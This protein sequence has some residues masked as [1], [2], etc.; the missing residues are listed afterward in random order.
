[1]ETWVEVISEGLQSKTRSISPALAWLRLA[2]AVGEDSPTSACPAQGC[3]TFLEKKYF[4]TQP[5]PPRP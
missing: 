2:M 3:T 1:M 5:E 4:L